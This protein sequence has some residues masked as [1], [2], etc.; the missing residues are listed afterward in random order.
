MNENITAWARAA[1]QQLVE[2]ARVR[3]AEEF[4]RL[5]AELKR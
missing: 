2:K 5:A 3:A 4:A 1:V